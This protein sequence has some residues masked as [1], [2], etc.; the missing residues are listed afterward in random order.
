MHLLPPSFL[1]PSSSFLLSS[2]SLCIIPLSCAFLP[3]CSFLLPLISFRTRSMSF[4]LM[5]ANFSCQR[6]SAQLAFVGRWKRWATVLLN[7]AYLNGVLARAGAVPCSREASESAEG[8]TASCGG[9][10]SCYDVFPIGD[11]DGA[12]LCVGAVAGSPR[13]SQVQLTGAVLFSLQP[14]QYVP[15]ASRR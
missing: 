12:K 1:L 11:A 5:G 9:S 7:N 2:F 14:L 4:G 13:G 3:P 8:F 6:R 15:A 10:R